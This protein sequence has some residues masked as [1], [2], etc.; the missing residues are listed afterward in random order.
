MVYQLS[1]FPPQIDPLYAYL[2][3]GLLFKSNTKKSILQRNHQRV[4]DN[5][6]FILHGV[7]LYW[8]KADGVGKP[9]GKVVI[10]AKAIV[11]TCADRDFCFKLITPLFSN[12]ILLSAGSNDEKKMW[13]S[14][15][16]A[17]ISSCVSKV[18]RTIRKH[19]REKSGFGQITESLAEFRVSYVEEMDTGDLGFDSDGEEDTFD[20]PGEKKND[21]NAEERKSQHFRQ[22][23]NVKFLAM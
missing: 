15:L 19:H 6:W 10:N 23:T 21:S 11:K 8:F 5:R 16:R 14:S 12:G 9:R 13:M 20:K 2:K 3:Q 7:N 1:C 4:W 17:S 18:D 22:K